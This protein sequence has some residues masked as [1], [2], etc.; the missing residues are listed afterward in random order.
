MKGKTELWTWSAFALGAALAAGWVYLLSRPGGEGPVW[1][2]SEGRYYGVL[3]ALALV[4]VGV[5]CALRDRPFLGRSR[6]AG[7]AV[8]LLVVGAAPFPVPYPS[9]REHRPSSARFRLPVDGTWRV[10]Y[11]GDGGSGPLAH[12]PERRFGLVL[13]RE[14]DGRRCAEPGPDAD[15]GRGPAPK[16]FFA[17]GAS[18]VAPADAT[19]VVSEDGHPDREAGQAPTGPAAGNHVVLQLAEG[20]FLVLAHLRQGSVQVK[21]GDQ[22]SAGAPLAEVGASGTGALWGEPH[23][24]VH[25]QTSSA[26]FGG[27]A[28]PWRITGYSLGGVAMPAGMPRGGVALG[29][30]LE[31]Q[32]ITHGPPGK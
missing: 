32:V 18:V 2:Y 27:E 7:F 4:A 3:V 30:T 31:G 15:L 17:F 14:V 8:L 16:D 22:V 25:L 26:A 24:S 6:G 23:V 28:V 11:G 5:V 29:G 21:A 9:S 10:V 12:L 19:V 20:E 13:V 1:F